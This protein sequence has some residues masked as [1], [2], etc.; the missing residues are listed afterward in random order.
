MLS[1]W[2]QYFPLQITLSFINNCLHLNFTH[3]AGTS[4][5]CIYLEISYW[6]RH[7]N[8]KFHNPLFKKPLKVITEIIF[9]NPPVVLFS[10]IL[11]HIYLNGKEKSI[12]KAKKRRNFWK[13][14]GKEEKFIS[15]MISFDMMRKHALLGV[16]YLKNTSTLW[17]KLLCDVV[18]FL[19]ICY[20][21]CLPSLYSK[22]TL[23]PHLLYIT[24]IA[25][26]Y[27]L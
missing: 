6:Y 4:P 26:I 5:E 1:K 8:P 11:S 3:M 20:G 18:L 7:Q 21:W 13:I 15:K 9:F 24:S 14:A 25:N 23:C 16:I 10:I 17:K 12:S 22:Q 27:I 2:E 19:Y